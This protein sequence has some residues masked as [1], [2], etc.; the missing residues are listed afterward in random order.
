MQWAGL[1]PTREARVTRAQLLRNKFVARKQALL[2]Q[3]RT[4]EKLRSGDAYD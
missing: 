3:K 1:K 4:E 2:E